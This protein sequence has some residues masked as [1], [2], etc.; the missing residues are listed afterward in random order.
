MD[1]DDGRERM[2]GK[3]YGPYGTAC[4]YTGQFDAGVCW[5]C[6]I[7]KLKEKV[8]SQQAKIDELM[9]EYCPS[10]MTPEQIAEYERHQVLA[11]VPLPRITDG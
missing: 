3:H 4:V 1:N 8:G 6:E 10:E 11:D 7:R 9:W 2:Y 5:K